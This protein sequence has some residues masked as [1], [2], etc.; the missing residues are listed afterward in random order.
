MARRD[1]GAARTPPGVDAVV[2]LCRVRDADLPGVELIEVQ[3]IDNE[4]LDQ[5]PHLGFVLQDTVSL[6]EQLRS[7]GRTVLLQCVQAQ[8]RT[9]TVAALHGARLRGVPAAEALA[10]VQRAL[11]RATP[12]AHFWMPLRQRQQQ[13][14]NRTSAKPQA[15]VRSASNCRDARFA[16]GA[17][18][19]PRALSGECMRRPRDEVSH[20]PVIDPLGRG[21]QPDTRRT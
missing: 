8:S 20:C 2:S 13:R 3:L 9:P 7:E 10:A 6:L 19:Y 1:Y 14:S 16:P 5:N 11:P 17:R 18:G 21:S 4:C 12:T 15:A